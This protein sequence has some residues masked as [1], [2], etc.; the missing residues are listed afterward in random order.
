[1]GSLPERPE[2]ATAV[3]RLPHCVARFL[4]LQNLRRRN[5]AV[6]R[7]E[8]AGTWLLGGDGSQREWQGDRE[9]RRVG[10]QASDVIDECDPGFWVDSESIVWYRRR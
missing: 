10:T 6:T 2:L 7:A 3:A 5:A 1:M 9:A 4:Y 8:S